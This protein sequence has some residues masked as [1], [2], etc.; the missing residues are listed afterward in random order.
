MLKTK[1][2]QIFYCKKQSPNSEMS[3]MFKLVNLRSNL[4]S[5]IHETWAKVLNFVNLSFLNLNMTMIKVPASQSG[6]ESKN[7]VH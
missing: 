7:N 6:F 5:I 1:A 2:P 3:N 4:G